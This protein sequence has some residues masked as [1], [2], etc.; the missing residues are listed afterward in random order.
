MG[1]YNP[2]PDEK[3]M[4][5]RCRERK[6]LTDFNEHPYFADG[7]QYWCRECFAE[8]RKINSDRQNHLR[9]IR[10]ANGCTN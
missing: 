5:S 2:A 1:D 8:Y 6:L 4:C 10:R 3:K 9:R 7:R